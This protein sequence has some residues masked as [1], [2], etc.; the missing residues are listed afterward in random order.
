VALIKRAELPHTYRESLVLDLADVERQ[1][2]HVREAARR[3]AEEMITDARQERDEILAGALERGYAEG[4]QRG[5]EEGRERGRSEAWEAAIGEA[6]AAVSAAGEALAQAA[7]EW[8]GARGAMLESA[9]TDVL[10][11][12]LAMGERVTKRSIEADPSRVLDQVASALSIVATPTSVVVEVAEEDLELVRRASA[13][14]VASMSSVE[15]VEVRAAAGM[16]RGSC[17]VRT[18]GGGVIDARVDELLDLIAR[19]LLPG[20]ADEQHAGSD[21]GADAST[22]DAGDAS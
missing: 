3:A 18:R 1:A 9:R 14:V 16:A 17:V 6:R 4:L 21:D 11:L 13:E 15:G 7:A 20:V 8:S 10:R 5:L 22:S 2:R 12:A 19:T